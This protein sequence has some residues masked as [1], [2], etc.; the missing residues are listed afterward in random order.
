MATTIKRFQKWFKIQNT[1]GTLTPL[2]KEIQAIISVPGTETTS[3][4]FGCQAPDD[5]FSISVPGT[6][7]PPTHFGCLAPN[8]KIAPTDDIILVGQIGA[9]G[10]Y[11]LGKYKKEALL[12]RLPEWFVDEALSFEAAA[13]HAL[14]STLI[15]EVKASRVLDVAEG[16]LYRTL[17][18]LGSQMD[19]GYRIDYSAI[20]VSQTTIEFCEVFDMDPLKLLSCGCQ[21]LV[22]PKESHALK[23]LKC[24]GIENCALIGE[25]TKDKN[26]VLVHR[27]FESLINRPDPDELLKLISR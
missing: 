7:M 1:N 13:H 24:A 11:L 4:P 21:L 9:A 12:S 2:D 8:D 6:E 10:T 27:D 26:K 17:A 14:S 23:K 16:G 3:T 18:E 20:P 25:I 19:Y 22:A 5:D 15:D